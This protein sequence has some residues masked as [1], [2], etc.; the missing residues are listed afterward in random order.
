MIARITAGLVMYFGVIS[1]TLADERPQPATQA[2]DAVRGVR[3]PHGARLQGTDTESLRVLIRQIDDGALLWVG[4]FKLGTTA[5]VVPGHH[6]IKVM[7]ELRQSWGTE[8][9]HGELTLEAEP[10]R[11]YDL[12][13]RRS[14]SEGGCDIEAKVR[15]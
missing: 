8:L 3:V 14:Q 11:I 9:K 7:C 5:V 12:V 1:V 13:G 10:D 15:P 4:K 2:A 6:K